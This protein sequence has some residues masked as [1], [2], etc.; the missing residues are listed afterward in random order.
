MSELARRNRKRLLDLVGT[1]DMLIV[2]TT[3]EHV[4]Y[5]SG[6]RSMSYDTD[7]ATRMAVVFD[8]DRGILVGHKADHWAAVEAMGDA[9]DY[10]AY[11][12]F[13]FDERDRTPSADFKSFDEALLAAVGQLAGGKRGM[14]FDRASDDLARILTG[15]LA[16]ANGSA[17]FR[18][19]RAIKNPLE[20][21]LMRE[22]S[23]LTE[24]ALA[25]AF[26]EARVGMTEADLTAIISS[27]MT[28]Q[29]AQPGF[30]VVTAGERSALADAYSTT[31]RL[32]AHDILRVDIGCRYN[33]YWSDTAR[34]AFIG[35]P[36]PDALAAFRAT[37]AGQDIGR[38]LVRPGISTDVI[39]RETVATVRDSGLPDYRRHHVGHGLG[40]ESHEYPT[41]SAANNVILEPGMVFCIEAPYYRPGWGGV[42]TEDTMVVT[43]EGAEFF[44][45]LSRDPI[46][47]AA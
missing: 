9:L 11:G 7:P 16:G 47:I 10:F 6:Y 44:T 41:I 29:G 24:R 45:H 4:F 42:M 2:A 25:R 38:K 30:V 18:R 5:C 8:A 26:E 12:T 43:A 20:I 19:A 37:A 17:M 36:R 15:T 22:A 40:L 33:G 3:P 13:F 31:R 46:I 35:E 32:R 28:T 34:S 1:A 27:E 21:D 39:F 23:A 14:V